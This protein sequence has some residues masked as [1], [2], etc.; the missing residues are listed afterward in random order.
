MITD[1]LK[2][3]YG[4]KLE[5]IEDGIYLLNGGK[6]YFIVTDS[7]KVSIDYHNYFE[8]NGDIAFT[9][10]NAYH[11]HK[12]IVNIKTGKFIDTAE[13]MWSHS[14]DCIATAVN[15]FNTDGCKIQVFNRDTFE[16]QYEIEAEY[17]IYELLSVDISEG[18][19]IVQ[20]DIFD[21]DYELKQ[22]NFLYNIEC[23]DVAIE[24]H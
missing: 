3:L 2:L 5:E 7:I 18:Y 22:V 8:I 14:K 4:N 15:D 10:E 12:R 1:K 6:E 20:A 21:T 19:V 9:E 17:T 23:G 11:E 13:C 16:M 24:E